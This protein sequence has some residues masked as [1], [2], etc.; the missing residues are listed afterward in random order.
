M[1]LIVEDGSYVTI[2]NTY[3]DQDFADT[4][5]EDRNNSTWAAA[6]DETKERAILYAGQ[7]LNFLNWKGYKMQYKQPMAWPRAG[8]Y[9]EDGRLI[10]YNII[11]SRV[12]YAQCEAA[13]R[14]LT[15][16]TLQPDLTNANYVKRTKVDILEKEYFSGAPA[17][18][19]FP[20]VKG[21]LKG[22][23]FGGNSWDL[24]RS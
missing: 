16:G 6:T 1:P 19:M 5:F 9:D 8:C 18:T 15:E 10:A 12:K 22:L 13:L 20:M 21:Y 4:Y 24:I 23:I 17:R 2:S 11:L 14:E 7:Y 3:I